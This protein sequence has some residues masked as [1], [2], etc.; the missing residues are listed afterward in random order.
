MK[1]FSS[2]SIFAAVLI[3]LSLLTNCK[4]EISGVGTENSNIEQNLSQKRGPG[5]P[6]IWPDTVKVTSPVS[7][8]EDQGFRLFGLIL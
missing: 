7:Q 4:K 1:K 3:S 5:L 2:I 8:K 6:I